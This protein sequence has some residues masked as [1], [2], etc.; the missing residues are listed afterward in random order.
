MVG[1]AGGSRAQQ[2]WQGCSRGAA[3]VQQ[4]CGRGGQGCIKDAAE[5]WQGYGSGGRGMI[6][7]AGV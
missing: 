3:E 7:V 5:V 1:V 2:V 4:R 6:G